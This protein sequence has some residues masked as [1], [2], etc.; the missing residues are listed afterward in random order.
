M[1]EGYVKLYRK[2]MSWE[3][4]TTPLT[5]HLFIH[6]LLRV[7]HKDSHWRGQLIK[8]GSHITSISKLAYDSGLSVEQVKTALKHLQS[9]NDITKISSNKNSLIIV[10]NYDWYQTLYGDDNNQDNKQAT[11]KQQT[12]NKQV[13]TNKN[14]KNDNN[15]KN[16]N[17]Y[18]Q[19]AEKWFEA[20]W[21]MYPKKVNKKKAKDK[22]IKICKDEKTY[23]AIMTG[24]RRQLHS[25]QWQK[26]DGLFI[27]HPLT[28]LNG[29]RWNDEVEIKI[30]KSQE[31]RG[32]YEDVESREDDICF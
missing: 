32:E 11:N 24:L 14:E 15:E 16:I 7:N 2:I 4:Y 17:I 13:T 1:D 22:F 27:P 20:F 25:N 6:L 21:K 23:Q 29:E 18:V 8:R 12:N 28:W 10:T 30:Q 31:E 5:C 9:T 26:D 19:I 3:W